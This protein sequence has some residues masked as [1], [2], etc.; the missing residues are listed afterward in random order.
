MS[1][2]TLPAKTEYIDK[3]IKVCPDPA[4]FA[5]PIEDGLAYDMTP[6]QV[7][8]TLWGQLV[9]ANSDRERVKNYCVDQILS[10]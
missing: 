7:M 4:F 9:I 3:P 6:Q 10:E 2:A 5:E 8:T 1:C